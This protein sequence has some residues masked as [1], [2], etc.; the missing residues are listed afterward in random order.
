MKIS[1][2]PGQK[3]ARQIAAKE[4]GSQ[5][6]Y[7]AD[8]RVVQARTIKTKKRRTWKLLTPIISTPNLRIGK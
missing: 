1:N 3:M 8:A 6:F 7:A 4:G 5:R 2:A